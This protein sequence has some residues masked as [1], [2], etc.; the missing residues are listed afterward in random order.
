MTI[1]SGDQLTVIFDGTCGFCTDIRQRLEQRD[2]HHRIAWVP[3]QQMAHDGETPQLCMRTVVSI[4]PDGTMNTG[5]QAFARI[6]TV[7]SGS[8]LPIQFATLPGL[9][10]LLSLGYRGIARVR[11]HLPGVTPWCDRHPEDCRPTP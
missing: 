11:R 2:R 8:P 5:A 4:T 9:C 1:A 10:S 7:L 6:L 3:C